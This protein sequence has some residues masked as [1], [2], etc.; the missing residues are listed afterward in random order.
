[1]VSIFNGRDGEW[2]GNIE[3]VSRKACTLTTLQQ[4]RK[5]SSAAGLVLAFA[6]LKKNPMDFL[7]TKATELGVSVLQPVITERTETAR[8]NLNR[9]TAQ[10]REAAEQCERLDVPKVAEPKSLIEFL[11]TWL[12]VAPLWTGDETGEGRSF[13]DVLTDW[14]SA[15]E[16]PNGHGILIGPEGGFTPN[17]FATLD[18]MTFVTRVDL[19]PRIL[20][21]ETAALAAL[22]CW[23]A[24][25]GDWRRLKSMKHPK[26]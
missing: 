11:N 2:L 13:P 5:Q 17:E 12:D 16:A 9:L 23:Q 19:G 1:K 3:A 7:V 4:T 18:L 14:S 25:L 20:R 6:P 10:S 8:I 24:L 26:N 15:S 22:T 21:A